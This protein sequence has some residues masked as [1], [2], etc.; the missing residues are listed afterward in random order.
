M[1]YKSLSDSQEGSPMSKVTIFC[2]GGLGGLLPILATLVTVDLAPVI[3]HANALTL[4]NYLG[5]GIRVVAL[6][7]L[8]GIMALLNGEVRQPLTLVQLGIAAPALITAY[9]NG[10]SPSLAP[11]RSAL[12]GI[13]TIAKADEAPARPPIQLAGGFL[14]DIIRGI[15]TPLDRLNE[16][17]RLDD[18]R[19]GVGNPSDL[20]KK[21]YPDLAVPPGKLGNFCTT[22]DGRFGPGPLNPLGSACHV[23]TSNGTV[24]GQV[25][26]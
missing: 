3:D 8:G 15:G 12:T 17:N 7:V 21:A 16:A 19:K 22:A 1:V 23:E 18:L 4:G 25:T 20:T 9:I 24:W 14:S 13:V 26:E 10:T 6:V 2:L 5:Y 11:Q